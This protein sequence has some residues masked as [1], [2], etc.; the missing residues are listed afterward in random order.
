MSSADL[1]VAVF[2][3]H[4]DDAPDVTATRL[5]IEASLAAGPRRRLPAVLAVAATAVVVLSVAVVAASLAR[6]AS[7]SG[8]TS[9]P[10]AAS[11]TSP[12]SVTV[13]TPPP[14]MKA[15]YQ[16][17]WLPPGATYDHT[18]LGQDGM[19]LEGYTF[20]SVVSA[21]RGLTLWLDTG[22]LPDR[23]RD[24][25]TLKST[26][27]A[28]KPAV[29]GWSP[30]S[31]SYTVAMRLSHNRTMTVLAYGWDR[32]TVSA[33]ATHTARELRYGSFPPP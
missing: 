33:Y 5:A 1:L 12:H 13:P 23:L 3:E 27:I 8:H 24:G 18:D 14:G 25:G 21:K 17:G 20:G 11:A 26:T 4:E 16:P 31:R 9:G 6:T 28:G 19:Y 7:G 10:A 29:E 22:P 2:A 30:S 15:P 32:A